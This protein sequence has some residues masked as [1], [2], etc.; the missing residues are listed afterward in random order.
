MVCN[1]IKCAAVQTSVRNQP[2]AEEMQL[3]RNVR[4]DS[5]LNTANPGLTKELK[6][7][8]W[9]LV[10]TGRLR[11]RIRQEKERKSFTQDLPLVKNKTKCLLFQI[12]W[13]ALRCRSLNSCVSEAGLNGFQ[14]GAFSPPWMHLLFYARHTRVSREHIIA[15]WGNQRTS[16]CMSRSR[17]ID[18]KKLLGRLSHY[19]IGAGGKPEH[20]TNFSTLLLERNPNELSS[21]NS[22][23]TE[24]KRGK[25][26]WSN[27][28][29]RGGRMIDLLQWVRKQNGC[30]AKQ[31]LP[32]FFF[33]NS[34]GKDI[35]Y[36]GHPTLRAP[37]ACKDCRNVPLL[38]HTPKV[39]LLLAID[40]KDISIFPQWEEKCWLQ[41]FLQWWCHLLHFNL[42]NTHN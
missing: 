1:L 28:G 29:G 9:Y 3:L 36:M 31:I 15:L 22:A 33:C 27:S 14:W 11:G 34:A 12:I 18:F 37:H 30:V 8:M 32:L 10:C 42:N 41:A 35:V 17:L 2:C 38:C 24:C 6:K 26:G 40:Q 39:G 20:G 7:E 25:L 16:Y 13:I 19:W 4:Q 23:D 21:G 5:T